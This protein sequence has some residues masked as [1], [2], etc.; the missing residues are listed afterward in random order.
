MRL[1]CFT[2]IK[3]EAAL[4]PAFLDQLEAF[5]DYAT[6]LDHS[7]FDKTLEII[8]ARNNPSIKVYSL[9]S[10]GYPQSQAASFFAKKIME[11]DNPDFL[12]FLDCDEFLPFDTRD[13]LVYFLSD[14]THYHY[15]YYY[16]NNICPSQFDGKDIFQ[17]REFLQC[18]V[19]S[20][21]PKVILSKKLAEQ[22]QSWFV[23]QGYHSLGV[24]HR[25]NLIIRRL[26]PV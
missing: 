10:T 24:N 19:K 20:K 22:P 9:D 11:E 18:D 16:W 3:N 15:L 21:I 25:I 23:H 17:R 14:K 2:M 7:S 12:F 4:L 6:I 1:A 5:F 26:I 8:S 13:D